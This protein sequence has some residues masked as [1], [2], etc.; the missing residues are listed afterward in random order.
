MQQDALTPKTI[1]WLQDALPSNPKLVAQ[2]DGD[3][4][5]FNYKPPHKIK[6]RNALITLF[7]KYH[8]DGKG[9][10]LFSELSDCIPNPADHI[11]TFGSQIIDVPTQVRK[12]NF[13]TI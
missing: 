9:A 11:Q 5:K 3:V 4:A 7:K 1:K 6:N 8:T 12:F 2:L 13:S 10:I